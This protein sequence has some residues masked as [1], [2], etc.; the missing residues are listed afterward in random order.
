MAVQ[1]VPADEDIFSRGG[2]RPAQDRV[3]R[4]SAGRRNWELDINEVY[5]LDFGSLAI[6]SGA[7]NFYLALLT[8]R[9]I[10]H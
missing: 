4:D 8:Q 10:V 5:P 9:E 2:A 1:N 3:S 6:S 7:K